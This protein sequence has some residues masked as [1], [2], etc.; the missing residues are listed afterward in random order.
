MTENSAPNLR[1]CLL[2]RQCSRLRHIVQRYTRGPT[3]LCT[4]T[5]G[6]VRVKKQSPQPCEASG[7]HS[8]RRTLFCC[9]S[10]KSLNC[11]VKGINQGWKSRKISL[12][13]LTA[14]FIEGP[15]IKENLVYFPRHSATLLHRVRDYLHTGFL[16]TLTIKQALCTSATKA[17]PPSQDLRNTEESL[18][19]APS[20]PLLII[21]DVS[22]LVLQTI[23][24]GLCRCTY[25]IIIT[26]EETS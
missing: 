25:L 6:G 17:L 1:A 9:S 23:K 4:R 13:Y 8:T 5:A 21:P 3:T 22:Q 24:L 12:L 20:L 2:C 11:P 14:C 19:Y 10:S 15:L 18:L 26:V 7:T 16:E